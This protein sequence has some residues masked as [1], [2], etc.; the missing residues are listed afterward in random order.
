MGEQDDERARQRP[1]AA[2]AG[3][4]PKTGLDSLR[5]SVAP[6]SAPVSGGFQV[7]VHVN[8]VEVTAAGAGLGMD[9]YDL[10]VPVNRLVAGP[11]PQT[12]PIARCTCGV[13]GCASTDITIIPDGDLVHWEW[14][15]NVPMPRGATFNAA[16]YDVEVTRAAADH[17]WETPQR[18]AERL[19]LTQVD[20]DHLARYRLRPDWVGA[21][22]RDADRFR[23]ALRFGDDYQ[24]F[25][26]VAWRGRSPEALARDLC[27]TLTRPPQHWDATWHAIS[28][29][30]DAPPPI[31]GPR[32]RRE[33]VG[34]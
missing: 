4:R 33:R 23:I 10:F 21:D 27:T 20:R 29:R 24:V 22:R 26:N 17:S 18:T 1:H 19:V 5:L 32:W 6:D 8:G 12:V 16:D 13:Y 15:Q 11:G 3:S 2:A 25:V 28:P 9:P 7:Q 30:H 14:S 31:V 34:R